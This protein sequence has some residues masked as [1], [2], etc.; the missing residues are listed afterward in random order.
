MKTMN[1]IFGTTALVLALSLPASAQ[2]FLDEEDKNTRIEE[3]MDIAN[4]VP[5]HFVEWDQADYLPVGDGAMLLGLLGGAYLLG[6][7]RKKD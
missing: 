6:K 2:V 3:G 5:Q 4:M 7:K 1:K